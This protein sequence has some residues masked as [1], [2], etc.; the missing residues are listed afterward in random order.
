MPKLEVGTEVQAY[1]RKCKE[2]SIHVITSIKN[3]MIDKVICN[4]CKSTH[5]YKPPLEPDAIEAEKAKAAVPKVK[6]SRASTAWNRAMAA[7]DEDAAIEYKFDKN[8]EPKTMIN[9]KKFGFGIVKKVLTVRK[10][11]VLFQ[12]GLKKLVQNT[13]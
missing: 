12:D 6:K 2:N 11:E 4:G 5:K 7:G 10:I 9:H 1:C 13:K 3:D 8:Y